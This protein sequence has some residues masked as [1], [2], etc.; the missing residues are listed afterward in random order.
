MV[1]DKILSEI[2]SP[3]ECAIHEDVFSQL[4]N[5]KAFAIW[6]TG[7]AGNHA[8]QNCIKRGLN[9][10]CICDSFSHSPNETIQGIPVLSSEDFFNEYH[11]CTVLIS[12]IA[13]Y[14]ISD[15]LT[16]RGIPIIEWDVALLADNFTGNDFE[17]EIQEN[18]DKIEMV[19]NL[20]ADDRSRETSENVLKYRL[21]VD[22]RCLLQILENNI[23]FYNDVVPAVNCNAFVDCGA[24]NG[25]TLEAFIKSCICKKY[26]AFEADPQNFDQLLQKINNNHLNMVK[27]YQLAVYKQKEVLKFKATGN[28]CGMLSSEGTISVPADSIDNIIDDETCVGY[29]K[30]DIEGGEIAALYGANQIIQRDNPILGISIYHRKTDLWKIPVL[31]HHMNPNYKLYVR[32]HTLM[33]VDTVC[34]ALPNI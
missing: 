23:Y 26:Y 22:K 3:L 15:I 7:I 33:M 12:C 32:H 1:V 21:T 27:P 10:V 30:M 25:D 19:Y 24:Y 14:G 11:D 4:K 18:K 8:A 6:G 5:T 13:E 16:R 28:A 9:P 17:S 2:N 31:I 20:L 34:Y 29:I